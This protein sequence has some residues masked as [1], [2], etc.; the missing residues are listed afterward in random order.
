LDVDVV[1]AVTA[2]VGVATVVVDVDVA[3][4]TTRRRNGSR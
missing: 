2:A 3:A 1:T 4:R